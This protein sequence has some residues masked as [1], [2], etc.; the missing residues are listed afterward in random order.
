MTGVYDA[1]CRPG[2]GEH[3]GMIKAHMVDDA[4]VV[5]AWTWPVPNRWWE[6]AEWRLFIGEI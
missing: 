3:C 5:Y 2:L 6:G 1:P 4:I